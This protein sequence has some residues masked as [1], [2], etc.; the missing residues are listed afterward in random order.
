MDAPSRTIQVS[1]DNLVFNVTESGPPD[2][3]PVLLLHGFPQHSDSWNDMV[4]PLNEAGYRTLAM[5]QRGYSPGARPSGRRAYRISELVEDAAA[6]I[7]QAAGGRAH[8]VGHDWGAGI[9]WV[10]ASTHP[11]R[12]HTLTALSVPHVGAFLRA[13]VTSVQ[14]LKSFYMYLFQLP[15]LPELVL[16]RYGVWGLLRTGQ[17]EERARRDMAALA[18]PGALTAALNYYRGMVFMD[19]RRADAPITRP[20]L[21]IWSDRDS[22][23]DR[24]GAERTERYVRGPYE[25]HILHGVSHWIPEEAPIRTAELVIAHQ[26][27]HPHP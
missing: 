26:R 17:T 9:A 7:D 5:D 4:G 16:R 3:E 24:R 15:W 18:A 10:L 21:F 12:V 25:F 1:R 8:V 23:I 19:P 27:K 13:M 6:V 14:G 2:G 20:T 22:A 11:D